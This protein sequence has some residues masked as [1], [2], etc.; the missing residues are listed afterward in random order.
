MHFDDVMK[1]YA[2]RQ[3]CTYAFVL[4]VLI[5]LANFEAL[6]SNL[7]E[8]LFSHGLLYTAVSTNLKTNFSKATRQ[9]LKVK[10]YSDRA[11]LTL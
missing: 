11:R 1:I 10:L 3:V 2:L 9:E 7:I 4:I 8:N 5:F 6:N